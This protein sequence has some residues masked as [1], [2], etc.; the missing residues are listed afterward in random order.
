MTEFKIEDSVGRSTTPHICRQY[1]IRDS[2]VVYSLYRDGRFTRYVMV[3][4]RN[5]YVPADTEEVLKTGVFLPKR[6]RLTDELDDWTGYALYFELIAEYE[7]KMTLDMART[8]GL[9]PKEPPPRRV[10]VKSGDL[11]REKKTDGITPKI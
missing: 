11:N 4:Q 3:K 7:Y 10:K 2:Q 5:I 1:Q 9:L 6:F 8:A